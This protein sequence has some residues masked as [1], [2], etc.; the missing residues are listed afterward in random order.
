MHTLRDVWNQP[1]DLVRRIRMVDPK[2]AGDL[3]A[4]K[5][6]WYRVNNQSDDDDTTEVFVY[7]IIGGWFGVDAAEFVKELQDITTSK[8]KVRINSPGGNVYDSIAIHNALMMHS[9]EITVYVDSLAA[10]GASVIAMAGDNVI[11][12]PGSQMMIH[13]ALMYAVGNAEELREQA[14]FLDGQ[15]Q[16]IAHMYATRAGGE[17]DDW[18]ERMLAETWYFAQ[19]AV[20]AGLADEV[21]SKQSTAD[22][23]DKPD[24][25]DD[26]PMED[27][28]NTS[29]DLDVAALMKI[30][31]NISNRGFKYPGRRKAPEPQS[32]FASQAATLIDTMFAGRH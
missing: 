2:L 3:D 26:E 25:D 32:S 22:D 8:I 7:D 13:D 18:R 9:A 6:S 14:D 17:P 31:H 4:L 20:D 23:E 11:M 24:E 28:E 12:L 19:E 27:V 30:K 15:S 16:N 5:L 10:S 29:H 1:S 21:Y